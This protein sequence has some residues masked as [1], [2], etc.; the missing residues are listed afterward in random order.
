M[1][2]YYYQKNRYLL[3]HK[4]N[5]TFEEVL[6]MTDDEFRQ[7]CIDVRHIVVYAWDILGMPPRV[8]YNTD[9]IVEQFQQMES[10]PVN[11]FLVKDEFT[12]KKDT[13]RNT[14][15]LGNA[16]NQWFPTMLAVRIN[17]T[18][19][20][21]GRS[22]YD[23]FACDDLLER[24]ITYS[25]RHFKRDSFYAYSVPLKVMDDRFGQDL[26]RTE[27]G[28][29]WILDFE[30]TFRQRGEY[31]Y[32][33][34]PK[35]EEIEYTGY[36]EDLKG[37][38]YLTLVDLDIITLGQNIPLNCQSNIHHKDT[39][40]YQIRV[41]K[42]G[43]KLFPIGLKAW[44]VSFNQYATNF[45]PLTAKWV[46]DNFLPDGPSVVW[47]PS[48]GWGGRL[49]GMLS[50]KDTKEITY[51]GN[52]PNLDHTTREGTKYSDIVK[53]YKNHAAKGGL[54]P[55]EHNITE[56]W[57]LGS[58]VMQ[59]ESEFQIYKG[60]VDLVF[61]SP[62][63]FNREA[64]SEDAGQ[65]YKKFGS[66][67]SWVEGFLKPTLETAYVWLKPGG[68]IAWNIAD[69]KVGKSF[70]PL[71]KDSCNIMEFLGMKYIT[72]YKMCMSQMP[73]ANRLNADGTAT[74]KNAVKVNG[75]VFRMEP[76]FIYQK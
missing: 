47:D 36:N 6:W 29:Y 44:R 59:Y 32:W 10:F 34:C 74:A 69:L 75:S 41:F 2:N 40:N 63:Y 33:L 67:A 37:K 64:Y 26:P 46:Y 73:G 22:I 50:A 48:M 66:Y 3:E 28:V 62:P 71:E 52:D 7:W 30:K 15:V 11:K 55:V 18:E 5:K 12:G 19:E 43:Q 17:Y 35:D 54:F 65:S 20:D 23:F 4:V 76:I 39:N 27:N 53:F 45:P 24:F 16:V 56:F 42:L 57:Q 38:E 1:I 58:E 13:L 14:H 8:G 70:L 51:L 9:E 60:Q 21:K 68:H 49:L 25:R 72:T 61:T 31:D